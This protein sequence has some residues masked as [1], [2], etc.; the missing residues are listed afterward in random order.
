MS[1]HTFIGRTTELKKLQSVYKRS[2]PGL[3]AVKGRRRIGKSRLIA[4]FAL[5]NPQ[6]AF[7]SFAG[8]APQEGVT[9]QQR[10]DHFARQ[11]ALFL[12]VPPLHL[13]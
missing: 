2:K 11:L 4:E 10:R 12:K 9:A 6:S 7:W 13:L 5:R 3:V 8:L 1:S